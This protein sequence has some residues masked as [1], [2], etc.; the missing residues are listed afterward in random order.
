MEDQFY[1]HVASAHAK[2]GESLGKALLANGF[3]SAQYAATAKEAAEMALSMIEPGKSVGIPGS[4]TIRQLGLLDALTAKGCK[5]YHH[6]D[7]TLTPDTRPQ[8]L[9]DEI[10][11]DW[12]VT[13][14]NAVTVDGKLVNIDGAGNRVAGMAWGLGKILYIFSLDKVM[15]DVETAIARVRARATP[16]NSIRVGLAP[17]CT[18]TGHCVNCRG[19][20]KACRVLTV[21]EAAPLGRDC[22]AIMVGEPLGY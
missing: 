6:W 16:A 13:S 2:L 5:V 17:A 21:L 8:R 3:T 18:K 11:A 9:L 15:P 10:T 7:P 22:R 12:F 14:T 19:A 1:K 4:V 20:E